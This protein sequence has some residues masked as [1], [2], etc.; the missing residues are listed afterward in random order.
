MKSDLKLC[1]SPFYLSSLQFDTQK[2]NSDGLSFD[3][4]EQLSSQ[5]TN[6]QS[7]II[8]NVAF[9]NRNLAL[10]NS[11]MKK[12]INENTVYFDEDGLLSLHQKTQGKIVEKVRNLKKIII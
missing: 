11:L 10:Y 9:Y 6:L 5:L 12:G 1:F 2:L 8:D 7:S 4:R 3:F